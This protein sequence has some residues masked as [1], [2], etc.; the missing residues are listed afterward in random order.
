VAA[1]FLTASLVR[2]P[3]LPSWAARWLINSE[4]MSA[5][6]RRKVRP[7]GEQEPRAAGDYGA[8]V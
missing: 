6:D 5:R 7:P 2:F 3:F 8:A 4:F 1:Y